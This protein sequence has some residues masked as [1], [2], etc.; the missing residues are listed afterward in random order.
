MG[1]DITMH[2]V[3]HDDNN[4]AIYSAGDPRFDIEKYPLCAY[5]RKN[6]FINSEIGDVYYK[7][8]LDTSDYSFN[9]KAIKLTLDDLLLIKKNVQKLSPR[10]WSINTIELDKKGTLK[11]L[12]EVI[13]EIKKGKYDVYA[14]C[15]W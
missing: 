15:S 12:R 3:K 7:K 13:A 2:F 5:W 11:Q 14:F 1:L 4:P 6:F 8:R 9:C 10:V